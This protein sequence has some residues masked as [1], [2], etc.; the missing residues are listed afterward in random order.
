MR[1]K[2]A[3]WQPIAIGLS[4]VNLVAVGFAAG[5]GEGWHAGVHA[6]LAVAFGLWAQRMRLRPGA[7]E[8]PADDTET[9]LE[10]LESDVSILRGELA[11]AQERLDFTERVLAQEQVPRQVRPDN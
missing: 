3:V 9:R 11:E 5:A 4:G 10:A 8:V 7:L 2:P 1:F 6:A